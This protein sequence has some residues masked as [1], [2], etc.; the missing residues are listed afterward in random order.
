MKT[1]SIERQPLD[2][3]PHRTGERKGT[4]MRK[5]WID[6]SFL[7][8]S[9]IL[10]CCLM[11]GCGVRDEALVFSAQETVSEEASVTCEN[12]ALEEQHLM[13]VYVCG[14]VVNPGVVE[15]PEGSRAAD[16]LRETGG[17]AEDAAR[18]SVNLA[19][20]VADGEMLY[21]PT[22]SEAEEQEKAEEAA[23]MG[24]VNINTADAAQLMTL[25]GIGEARARDIIAYRET[26][27]AFQ[28]KEDLQKVSGI[29]ENMYAKLCD[30]ITIH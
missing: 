20:K 15:L 6:D 2:L 24:L 14:A 4:M 5:N 10:I 9:G 16:A 8:V 12:T 28:S 27:G 3:N 17:F 25:P 23:E 11:C 29:K 18:E 30:R 7:L 1:V 26:N 13:C 22:V 19:A 21:F